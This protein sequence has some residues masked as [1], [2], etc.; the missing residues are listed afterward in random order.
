MSVTTTADEIREQIQK[1]INYSVKILEDVN[2]KLNIMIDPE[3]WG[4]SDWTDT[5]IE[6]V[7]DDIFEIMKISIKLKKLKKKY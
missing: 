4:G 7:N 6:N 5:F 1:R 2:N 3:T